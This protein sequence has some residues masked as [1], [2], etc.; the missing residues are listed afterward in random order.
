LTYCMA[1]LESK[2][3]GVTGPEEAGSDA[4]AEV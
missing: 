3:G 4:G 1:R 2:A